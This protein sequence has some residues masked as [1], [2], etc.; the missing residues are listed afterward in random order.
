M[1]KGEMN[2]D[3]IEGEFF[4]TEHL[5]SLAD[6]LVR[7]SI[8]NSLDAGIPGQ[9]VRVVFRLFSGHPDNNGV[10]VQYLEGLRPHLTAEQNGLIQPPTPEEPDSF[11]IIEDYGTRGLEGDPT[12]DDDRQTQDGETKNDFFYFW[13]NI[14][15]SGK[16]ATDRGRWGLGKTVFQVTSRINSF[17]GMTVRN[18]DGKRFLMGQSVLKTHWVDEKKHSPYGWFGNFDENFA[19]PILDSGYLDKFS[20]DWR[21]QRPEGKSGLSVVIPY[22]DPSVEIKTILSSVLLHYFFP[23][24][25]KTLVVE[26]YK[27][28]KKLRI[29]D[30]KIEELL[31]YV[32]FSK[33][34]LNRDNFERLFSF[35]RW[36]HSLSSERFI[37]LNAPPEDVAP[38]WD[39]S[40]FDPE[41]LSGLRERFE[42]KE[43]LALRVPLFIKPRGRDPQRTFFDVFIE[44]DDSLDKAEDHFIREGITMAGISTLKQK[45]VRAVV[46]VSDKA[47][48]AL[49]GDSENPAHTEWQ[50]RSPK[51]KDRYTHGVSCLRFVK[52]SPREIVRIL[53]QTDLKKDRKLLEDFFSVEQAIPEGRMGSS[54]GSEDK[55]GGSPQI[56]PDLIGETREW[57]LLKRQGGFRITR[58][59]M[60]SFHPKTVS[61]AVAYE[62][63]GHNPF[64]KYNRLDFEFGKAPIKVKGRGVKLL[65]IGPDRNRLSIELESPDFS[66]EVTG[67]DLNRDL[68]VEVDTVDSGSQGND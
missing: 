1:T 21:L 27:D 19:L 49:L 40:C 30:Q 65:P 7:E 14:G 5:D 57:R 29:D 16:S 61:I 38:K 59:P 66:V 2:S 8:Q 54:D 24:L 63:R 33:S 3:P 67:F 20:I 10:V 18:S 42:N 37:P 46:S 60:A 36:A 58:N 44:R 9:T 43:R 6:G 52:N 28:G 62:I 4:S 32:D 11:L 64:R 22:P 26:L 13:R 68:R 48:S 25:S 39:D 35:T 51:F 23:V 15:R 56:P 12:Q 45:G 53:S 47:L 31:K 34:R 17:F 41:K 55:P 50:E